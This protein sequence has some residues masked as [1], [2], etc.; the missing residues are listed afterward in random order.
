[1]KLLICNF[2]YTIIFIGGFVVCTGNDDSLA[3]EIGGLTE[4]TLGGIEQTILI[5]SNDFSK[6]I[7]LILHGG[8]GYAMLPLLH[9]NNQKLEDHFIIVNWDQRGAGRSYFPNIPKESMTLSQF[10]SDAYE[11]T[12]YLKM[13][14]DRKKL[15]IMGHS[16]GTILGLHLLKEHP[17]DYF[18]FFG[19]GQV[20]DVIENEQ[21]SYDFALRSAT[22]DNNK[23]AISELKH[24]G[25]PNGQGE[26]IDASGYEITMKWMSNYGG[27]LYRK[28]DSGEI[29]EILLNSKI[30]AKHKKIS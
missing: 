20:V 26:Y 17:D 28:K 10:L 6:P 29:E 13:R 16:F 4:V 1:M 19:V 27:D 3:A 7:L 24:I 9:I 14:F 18:A 11:L 5:Q 30:Y 8:P 22:K 12:K 15:F 25:R 2:I 21:L 23:T